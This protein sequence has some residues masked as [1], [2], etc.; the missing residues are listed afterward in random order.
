MEGSIS[1]ELFDKFGKLFREA[2]AKENRVLDLDFKHYDAQTLKRI[3]DDPR[4]E[5]IRTSSLSSIVDYL[6]NSLE[7]VELSK[8]FLHVVSPQEV[9]LLEE[10]RGEERK[11]TRIIVASREND[12]EAFAFGEWMETEE[13]IIG[14]LS[15][16]DPTDDRETILEV[17]SSLVSESSIANSNEGAT[18]KLA[19]NAG[20][21]N[22][23]DVQDSAVPH[24]ANLKPFRTFREVSQPESAF[25]FRYRAKGGSVELVLIEADG[26]AW[27]HDAMVAIAEYFE[28]AISD[29]KVIA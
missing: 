21:V 5:T 15:L 6:K 18:M 12:A 4:P 17:S 3:F 14:L 29:L 19:V 1:P 27:K 28:T 9:E 20:V 11:R 24:V 26:G 22:Q 2:A 10:Y 13:F 8:V 16:F 25:V 7:H 23:S